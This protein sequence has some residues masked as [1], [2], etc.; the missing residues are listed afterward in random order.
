MIELAQGNL[1]AQLAIRSKPLDPA[2]HPEMKEFI[3]VFNSIIK[4]LDETAKVWFSR[5]PTRPSD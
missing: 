1:T 5:L 3:S 4:S 2:L